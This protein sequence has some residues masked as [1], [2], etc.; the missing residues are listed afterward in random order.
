MQ[1][2]RVSQLVE[3]RGDS[4]LSARFPLIPREATQLEKHS[5]E[6]HE[7]H[8]MGREETVISTGKSR[9]RWGWWWLGTGVMGV[10]LIIL[11]WSCTFG[12]KV[13][14]VF[15]NFPLPSLPGKVEVQVKGEIMSG[16]SG[17]PRLVHPIMK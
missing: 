2:L 5:I 1:T 9:P 8:D 12:C 6:A 14:E 13:L 16:T 7:Q 3:G 4:L 11:K 17:P 10:P 15:R